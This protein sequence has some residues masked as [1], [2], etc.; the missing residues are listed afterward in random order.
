MAKHE[1]TIQEKNVENPV[2]ETAKRIKG[3]IHSLQK[4]KF[5]HRESKRSP[6]EYAACSSRAAGSGRI[7][8]S[9]DF[10]TAFTFYVHMGQFQSS[11]IWI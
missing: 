3:K 8:I 1:L 6:E 2:Q 7:V 5:R 11:Q 4:F 10:K 9:T